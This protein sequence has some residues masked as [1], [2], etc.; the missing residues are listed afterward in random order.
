VTEGKSAIK[1]MLLSATP[2]LKNVLNTG[3]NTIFHFKPISPET[4]HYIAECTEVIIT[5]KT[6]TK[7]K[8]KKK[9][10]C[11]LYP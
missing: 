3:S 8:N 1:E 6:K 9:L 10:L 7:N 5:E 2:K 11:I 4:Q